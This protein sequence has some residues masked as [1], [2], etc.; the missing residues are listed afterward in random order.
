LAFLAGIFHRQV[1]LTEANI[2][3]EIGAAACSINAIFN[4]IYYENAFWFFMHPASHNTLCLCLQALIKRDGEE[5]NSGGKQG[6][7]MTNAKAIYAQ[8]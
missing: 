3:C 1:L 8:L 5:G 4:S 6:Q 2:K 7:A